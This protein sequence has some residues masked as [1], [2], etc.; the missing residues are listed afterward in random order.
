MSIATGLLAI[1]IGFFGAVFIAAFGHIIIAILFF[2][3]MVLVIAPNVI[4]L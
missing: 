2:L 3:F 4:G 1:A